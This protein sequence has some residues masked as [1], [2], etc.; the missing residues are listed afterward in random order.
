ATWDKGSSDT[1]ASIK[2]S[3]D[4]RTIDFTDPKEADI[5]K[6]ANFIDGKKYPAAEITLLVKSSFSAAKADAKSE[7]KSVSFDAAT[8]TLSFSNDLITATGDADDPVI[9]SEVLPPVFHLAGMF[10]A[11]V[12]FFATTPIF[13]IHNGLTTYF[14]GQLELLTY[15]IPTNEF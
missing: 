1:F 4:K 15:S 5:A 6:G 10:G 11:N 14:T 3:D 7:G 12:S 9:G 2:R 8:Q 13:T